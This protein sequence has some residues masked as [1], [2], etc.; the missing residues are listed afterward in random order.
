M[1]KSLSVLIVSSEVY[2]FSKE[3]SIGDVTFSLSLALREIGNDV[4]VMMPKYGSI[5]E[6]KNKIHEINRLKDIP[7]PIGDTTDP[8]TIKSSSINNPRNKVQAY[9][10]TNYKYFDSRKGIYHD[11]NTWEEYADNPERFIYFCR[12]VIETCVLL[13]WY[14]DIIHCNDWQAAILPAIAKE[15]YP[16]QFK[17]TRFVFTFHNFDKQGSFPLTTFKKTGLP[18]SYEKTATHKRMFNFVKLGLTYADYITTVS[19]IYAKELLADKSAGNGLQ[20]VLKERSDVFKGISN[21]IDSWLWNPAKDDLIAAKYGKNF[22]DYKQRNKEVLCEKFELEYD[23]SKFLIAMVTRIDR[24]KGVHFIV[25][26]AEEILQGNVQLIMLGQG[27]D[28]LKDELQKLSNKYPEKF[29]IKISFDDDLA[30]LIEAGSDAYII[31]SAYEPSALKFMYAAAYGSVPIVHITGGL[32][33]Y[34]LAWTDASD[35]GNCIE[36]KEYNADSLVAS[37]KKAEEL[38]QNKEAWSKIT[39]NAISGNYSWKE[40][41]KEY[42]EIYRKLLK[43]L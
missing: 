5:S 31:S 14:P 3:S 12:S 35:K 20:A 32:K 26:A 17:K 15:L 22:D 24:E 41:A 2:P 19:P 23:E 30:H 1:A 7:I 38:Y 18:D 9:I 4:R 10:T 25:E 29:K 43:D 40:N 11:P 16:K 8:G 33:H 36:I 42:D 21:A 13:G 39:M 27:N 37:V 28:E 6:R 34:A